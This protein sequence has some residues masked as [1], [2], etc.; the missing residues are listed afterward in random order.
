MSTELKFNNS[1]SLN[2]SDNKALRETA[3]RKGIIG[4][5]QPMMNAAPFVTTPNI[6]APLGALNYIRPRA[7]EVLTAPQVSDKI[8]VPEKNGNWG[9]KLV[10]IKLKEFT[11]EVSTDDGF[12]SDGLQAKTNYSNAIR[13]VYYYTT[14]WLSTEIEEAAVGAFQEDHRANQAEAAMRT[15]ALFRNKYFFSGVSDKGLTAP[16]EGLLN[17]SDLNAYVSVAAGA[18]STNPTYWVNKTSDE[19]VNDIVTAK[20]TLNKQSMGLVDDG[21]EAGRGKMI[22]AVA[23]GSAGQL[24]RTNNFG[25]TA[26]KMLKEMYGD[27]LEIVSVPQFDNAYSNSD[28]FYLVYSEDDMPTILNSYVEMARAYPLTVQDSV[29]SQKI[30]A[31]TS[32]CIV[33]YPMFIARFNG[34][35][36]TTH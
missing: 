33:Q 7:I 6:N 10:T 27:K 9:E 35:G 24:D 15:L 22:L 23:T 26:R 3:M 12:T 31:A 16:V 14:S 20:A 8:A 28:V 19:I 29:I 32:G 21:L 11:G 34:I 30:S 2:H 4:V 18:G 13:G 5:Q 36:A 17:A 1:V 25:L